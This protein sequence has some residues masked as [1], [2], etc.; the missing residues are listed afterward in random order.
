MGS[1]LVKT[2]REKDYDEENIFKKENFRHHMM[3]F[4]RERK[5]NMTRAELAK[6]IDVDPY[7]IYAWETPDENRAPSTDNIVKLCEAFDCEAVDLYT[8]F[9][10]Q[11]LDTALDDMIEVILADFHQN[12]RSE[13]VGLKGIALK[14]FEFLSQVRKDQE[15]RAAQS[16]Q[17]EQSRIKEV[18]L[19]RMRYYP[20]EEEEVEEDVGDERTEYEIKPDGEDE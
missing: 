3:R 10:P 17:S 14:E 12:I 15:L 13:S 6:A 11:T 1:S 8:D 2:Q 20:E 4:F 18:E 16:G 19:H 5:V 7:T 9:D